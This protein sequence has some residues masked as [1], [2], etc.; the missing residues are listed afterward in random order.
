MSIQ[1][2]DTIPSATFR[3]VTSEGPKEVPSAEFFY[4]KKVLLVAAVGAWTGTC[5]ND[6][7]PSILQNADAILGKG[8][9][10]IAV[11]TTNDPFVLNA[12][13]KSLGAESAIT[14]IS[15]GNAEW[16]DA[17]GMTFDGAAAGLGKRSLRYAMVVEGNKVT[18]LEVEES[19]GACSVTSGS[20]LLE[21]L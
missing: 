8:I 21:N 16:S 12:W 5:N 17:I 9:D 1:I 3:V 18:A 4:D 20:A 11:L 13:S 6:H 2:G 14:F 7:L 19:P 15:D 10:E